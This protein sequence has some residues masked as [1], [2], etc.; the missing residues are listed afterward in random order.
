MNPNNQVPIIQLSIFI[1]N[2]GCANDLL[3]YEHLLF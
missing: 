1:L 2:I 3:I